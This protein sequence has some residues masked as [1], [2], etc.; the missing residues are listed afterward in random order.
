VNV[1]NWL[2]YVILILAVRFLRLSV[3]DCSSLDFVFLPSADE[4]L[5]VCK[6]GFGPLHIE[7]KRYVYVV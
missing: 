7:T 6:F 2:S 4:A 3:Y 1:V 5:K